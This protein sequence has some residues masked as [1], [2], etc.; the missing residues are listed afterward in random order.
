MGQ[1]KCLYSEVI[2]TREAGANAVGDAFKTAVSSFPLIGGLVAG[3]IP[4]TYTANVLRACPGKTFDKRSGYWP[5]IV[6]VGTGILFLA[7]WAYFKFSK[8]K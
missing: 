8:R 4:N 7:A 1:N 5:E 2:M 6:L 3:F